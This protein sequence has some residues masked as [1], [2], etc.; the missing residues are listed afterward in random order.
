MNKNFF[1]IFIAQQ[2]TTYENIREVIK[3]YSEN[4]YNSFIFIDQSNIYNNNLKNVLKLNPESIF[5]FKKP[6]LKVVN[7]YSPSYLVKFVLISAQFIMHTH[8]RIR[9]HTH[10]KHT[11]STHTNTLSTH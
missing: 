6:L 9:A 10:T 11:L 8:A 5:R 3:K 7:P 4:T 1:G 2:S